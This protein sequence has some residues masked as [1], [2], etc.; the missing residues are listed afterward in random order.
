MNFVLQN[1]DL[2]VVEREI[3]VDTI[4]KKPSLRPDVVGLS[5]STLSDNKEDFVKR[6][7]RKNK[8]KTFS[9]STDLL[10]LSQKC[11]R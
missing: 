3:A 1:V 9:W 7:K 4:M 10:G 11:D 8:L 6:R 5:S 2:T